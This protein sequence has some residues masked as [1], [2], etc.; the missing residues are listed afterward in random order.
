MRGADHR[1][2]PQGVAE[3]QQGCDEE[4]IL[5]AEFGC[6]IAAEEGSKK[7]ADELEGLIEAIN[8][9]ET[10]RWRILADQIIYRRQKACR[11]DAKQEAQE[12]ELGRIAHEA[13]RNEAETCE[14]QREEQ[15]LFR[16]DAVCEMADARGCEHAGE[17]GTGE[18]GTGYESD[19]I[20]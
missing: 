8:A 7:I 9:S 19:V 11:G 3:Q 2:A 20:L 16:A 10:N 1:A 6:D 17:A 13:L 5:Y 14:Q 4:Y 18:D 15:N 12:A